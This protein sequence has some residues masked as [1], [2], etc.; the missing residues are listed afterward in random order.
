LQFAILATSRSAGR[1]LRRDGHPPA[2]HRRTH[3]CNL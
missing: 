1:A 3:V 2:G